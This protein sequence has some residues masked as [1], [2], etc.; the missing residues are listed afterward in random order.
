MRMNKQLL[1]LLVL[2]LMASLSFAAGEGGWTQGENVG[3]TAPNPIICWNQ[4]LLTAV[5][6]Y[7]IAVGSLNEQ[8]IVNGWDYIVRPGLEVY[9]Q[10]SMTTT[11]KYMFLSGGYRGGYMYT[12]GNVDTL[13]QLTLSPDSIGYVVYSGSIDT[14]RGLHSSL[15]VNDNLYMFGG[16]NWNK[17]A[18]NTFLNTVSYAKFNRTTERLEAFQSG[19]P[20]KQI[21]GP[22]CSSFVLGNKVYCYGTREFDG[23][24][25]PYSY[26]ESADIQE[27]GKLGPWTVVGG[28]Y[29]HYVPAGAVFAQ[30]STLFV[31]VNRKSSSETINPC[32]AMDLKDG[33]VEGNK[34]K[35]VTGF[36]PSISGGSNIGLGYWSRFL[37]FIK[38]YTYIYDP[39]LTSAPLFEE[40]NSD[41]NL[42]E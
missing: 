11:D 13:Y 22:V 41:S 31:F 10:L 8:G 40:S 9:E 16:R 5:P 37:Y 42:Y 12:G 20:F 3:F 35:S 26:I 18:T 23:D 29:D 19:Y 36:A 33:G 28:P 14:P 17:A 38:T 4:K 6:G 21:H 30:Q 24:V 15:M 7:T 34:F 1:C 39:L 27:D 25:Y 2:V 32:Y